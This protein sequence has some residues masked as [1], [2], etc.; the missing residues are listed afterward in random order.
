MGDGCRGG[1]RKKCTKKECIRIGASRVSESTHKYKGG[2]WDMA[3]NKNK[4][5]K[6]QTKLHHRARMD[7]M[8]G[9]GLKIKQMHPLRFSLMSPTMV[10]PT[11]PTLP[12][13]AVSVRFSKSGITKSCSLV[14][15]A[16]FKLK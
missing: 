5:D 8:N 6:I 15:V 11:T 16:I 9:I 4:E 12:T 14:G 1:G 3:E 2:E 10:I 7:I 13:L